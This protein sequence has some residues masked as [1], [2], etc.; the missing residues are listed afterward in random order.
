MQMWKAKGE[1]ED[2]EAIKKGE[3]ASFK[4]VSDMRKHL[5]K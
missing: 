4:D 3:V 5:E 1:K 2:D